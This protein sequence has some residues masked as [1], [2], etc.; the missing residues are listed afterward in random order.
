LQSIYV[1]CAAVAVAHV[2]T[3]IMAAEPV[4]PPEPIKK[5]IKMR[6]YLVT[7]GAAACLIAVAGCQ[8]KDSASAEDEDEHVGHVIPAHKP[9]TFPDAVR[10]LRE[11]H[12][13]IAR[14]V[15]ERS[16]DGAMAIALDV[17]AWLPEIAADSEMPEQ[18]WNRVNDQA[19]VLLARYEVLGGKRSGDPHTA[20]N[21]ADRAISDLEALLAGA[22]PRWF[23]G[24]HAS[25]K[26]P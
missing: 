2:L 17:A 14:S 13:Q 22:D 11:L 10:R 8:G 1:E 9:K 20:L 25:T 18:P 24:S 6:K 7:L 15:S 23:D 5:D 4:P 19:G 16:G 21:A 3:E 12:P 26:F